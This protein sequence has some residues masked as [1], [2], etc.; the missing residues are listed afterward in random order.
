MRESESPVSS[1]RGV[2]TVVRYA[3]VA[4]ATVAIV[5][6]FGYEAHELSAELGPLAYPLVLGVGVASYL[7]ARVGWRALGQY[8]DAVVAREAAALDP[9]DD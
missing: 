6:A 3:L 2:E 9:T 7:I 4:L 8:A 1:W 5:G